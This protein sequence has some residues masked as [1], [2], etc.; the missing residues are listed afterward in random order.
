[1]EKSKRTVTQKIYLQSVWRKTRYFKHRKCQNLWTNNK[2]RGD[3]K[4]HL[5]AFLP[6]LQKIWS[7]NFPRLFSNMA[8]V[9]WCHVDS[10]ANSIRFPAVQNFWKSVKIWQSY[11][12]LKGGNNF[13]RHSL[14]CCCSSRPWT[15]ASIFPFFDTLLLSTLFSKLVRLVPFNIF[16]WNSRSSR[17]KWN[18]GCYK[19]DE[20]RVKRC[21]QNKAALKFAENRRNWFTRFEIKRRLVI[22]VFWAI[23]NIDNY[24]NNSSN[25]NN[26]YCNSNTYNALIK[27]IIFL[28]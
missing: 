9:R 7:F 5:F 23:L 1:M 15:T 16:C 2:V 14:V 17:R 25:N 3:Y 27:L 6:H 4:C 24:K 26:N 19:V 28:F 21:V 18:L 8:K 12:Q 20:Y 13:L 11:R 10:V 22:S